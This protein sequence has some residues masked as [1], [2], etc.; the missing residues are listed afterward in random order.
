[1]NKGR[2]RMGRVGGW[3]ALVALLTLGILSFGKPAVA[4]PNLGRGA[5][6]VMSLPP[7]A[8]GIA[9]W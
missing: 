6:F 7:F 3:F 9:A 5:V 2:S 4:A 8:Q 1:M